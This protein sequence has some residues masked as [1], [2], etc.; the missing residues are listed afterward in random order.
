MT[1]FFCGQEL[2]FADMR[3]NWVT[4][5]DYDRQC[6]HKTKE[7]WLH[8][9]RWFHANFDWAVSCSWRL[10]GSK[11]EVSSCLLRLLL[12]SFSMVRADTA[13]HGL[14]QHRIRTFYLFWRIPTA[15]LLRYDFIKSRPKLVD[16]LKSIPPWAEYQDLFIQQGSVTERFKPYL[17]ILL[18]EKLNHEQFVRK[19]AR[20]N[21]GTITV[22]KYLEKK[23]LVDD[24]IGWM[25]HYFPGELWS[26]NKSGNSRTIVDYLEHC[27]FKLSKGLGYWDDSP[28]FLGET[29][30]AC[31]DHQEC[32]VRRPPC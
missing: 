31:S 19:M 28:K 32:G 1:V 29:F 17:Y 6:L 5:P 7:S 27:K 21:N 8:S 22:S 30:T 16:F 2:I 18:R 12:G 11:T 3:S 15:P 25:N 10:P 14:P 24:C 13:L 23:N 4:E 9:I 26:V 20:E